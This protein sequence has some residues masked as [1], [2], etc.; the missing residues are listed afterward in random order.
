MEKGAAKCFTS[1]KVK[2]PYVMAWRMWFDLSIER[3]ISREHFS[4]PP[5]VDSAMVSIVRKKNPLV[6][7]KNVKALHLLLD[8]GLKYHKAH[9]RII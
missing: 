5:K 8:F 1:N 6:S 3:G 2:D 4:P 9:R 7:Y